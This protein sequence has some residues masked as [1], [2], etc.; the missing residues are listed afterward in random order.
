MAF[1]EDPLDIEVSIALAADLSADPGTWS[2][3]DITDYVQERQKVTI[4][5]G[6]TGKF[7][8]VTASRCTMTVDNSDG[9]FSRHNPFGAWYGQIKKNTPL[10]V[11]VDNGSGYVTRFAGYVTGWPPAWDPSESDQTATISAD[12]IMRRMGRDATVRSP[13][14]RSV[15]GLTGGIAPFAYWPMEDGSTATEFASAIAGDLPMVAGSQVFT[16]TPPSTGS[17]NPAAESSLAGSLPLPVFGVACSMRCPI[18]A[19][20]DT[21]QWV[22][23]IMLRMPSEMD[24]QNCGL[25]DLRTGNSTLPYV[26]ISANAQTATT[27]RFRARV[28]DSTVSVTDTIS[29]DI[30]DS[31]FLNRWV[32]I[33]VASKLDGN[34]TQDTLTLSVTSTSGTVLGT[35]GPQDI[36]A[37]FHGPITFAEVIAPTGIY[38]PTVFSIGG[39]AYGHPA[40]FTDPAFTIGT[41]DVAHA[42]AAGGHAGET[43]SDRLIRLCAEAGVPLTISGTS[44]MTMGPQRIARDLELMR[45]CAIADQGLFFEPLDFGLAYTVGRDLYNQSP[46]IT[47]QYDQGHVSPPF[48]PTDDDRDFYNDVTATRPDGIPRRATDDDSI[49][50][51]GSYP[52]PIAPNVETEEQAHQIAAWAATV[53]SN[54]ELQWPAVKPN[55]RG[56]PG[57]ID[58]WLATEIGNML[59]V[60]GHPSPL[61]PATIEQI[62]DGYTEILGTVVFEPTVTLSSATVYN[63]VGVYG[64]DAIVSRYDSAGSTLATGYDDNDTSFSVVTA[65]GHSPWITTASHPTHFPFD[66]EVE[67]V[68][69]TVTAITNAA[70]PQ[71]FTVTRSVDGQDKALTSGAQVS[72]W[73]P[74]RYGL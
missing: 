48:V 35:T 70:S 22:W 62:V 58:D 41:D 42:I 19:Y 17:I 3:T 8:Q 63:S 39:G 16:P 71:T 52:L 14:Y 32:L 74:W 40:I 10:R 43:A 73:D 54:D 18:R 49:A 56:A 5:R 15:S 65:A 2:W 68:R 59:A 23:L 72:L 44:D 69:I 61:A 57:L 50:D 12:G 38:P 7:T 45:D 31:D 46:A 9:R 27:W 1:P 64:A 30:N 55:L 47:L 37:N 28:Y 60:T 33:S 13:M 6:K 26:Y 51:V 34:G 25:L 36:D 21:G 20:T 29:V 24:E 53:G 4:R 11:R 67:G 66:I